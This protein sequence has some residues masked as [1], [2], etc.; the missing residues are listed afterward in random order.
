MIYM[1]T[2]EFRRTAHQCIKEILISLQTLIILWAQ[3]NWISSISLSRMTT[4]TLISRQPQATH[5]CLPNLRNLLSFARH[6]YT[7]LIIG[8]KFDPTIFPCPLIMLSHPKRWARGCWRLS[9]RCSGGS[10]CSKSSRIVGLG[11]V[12]WFGTEM[13]GVVRG[14]RR[15]EEEEHVGDG[16][17]NGK[18]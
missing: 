1:P 12:L 14:A 11:G 17:E 6:P 4:L 5:I 9:G 15:V 13:L 2:H 16:S 3:N 7:L 18:K 10:R 8:H